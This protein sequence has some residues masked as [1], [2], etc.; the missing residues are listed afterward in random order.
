MPTRAAERQGVD[1]EIWRLAWPVTV[2]LMAVNAVEIVDIAM[3]SRLGR[4]SLAAVGYAAQYMHLVVTLVESVAIAAVA[5]IARAVGAGERQRARAAF[6]AALSLAFG[7]AG[8]ATLAVWVL[9]EL[10]LG[11]LGS[12]PAVA[13]LSVPYFRLIITSSLLFCPGAMFAAALRAERD[14]RTPL[15]AAVIM[16]LV[17]VLL[18]VLLIFGALGLPRLELVG[19]GVATLI[20]HGV[21]LAFY[22]VNA[23]RRR[24]AGGEPILPSASALRERPRLFAETLRVSLPAIAERGLSNVALLTYFSVLS[25]YGTAAIATYTIGVRLLAFSWIP[26]LGCSQAA[27][28]LVGQALGRGDRDDAAR[29]GWRSVRLAL[30][31]M[32]LIGLGCLFFR[33][34]LA[35]AFTADQGVIAYLIPFLISLAVAQ[36]FMGVHFTL[37]GALRGAGDTM[38]PMLGAAAGNWLLRI[39]LALTF[40]HL[41]LSVIWVW[42]ALVADHIAR[43]VF[44]TLAFHRGR[45]AT[46]VGAS[47]G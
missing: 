11:A 30:L 42:G 34:D 32:G 7:I 43:S 41:G 46:R 2:S 26:G 20:A 9:P 29:S 28:T 40:A 35:R 1:R 3:V 37:S 5:L 33:G 19:A 38:T 12:E 25:R 44:Y 22:L 47:V 23:L 45:W 4:D 14:T 16:A 13:Q 31:V 18:N 6:A 36:P 15:I 24:A 39:P 17:K 8:L 27:A 21:A 10:L